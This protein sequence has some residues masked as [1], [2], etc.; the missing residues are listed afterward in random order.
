MKI[1]YEYSH[2]GGS[3]ILHVRYPSYE[4]EIYD[5]IARVK[6]HR[7]KVSKEKTKKGRALY[8]PISMNEQFHAAF[9]E[10]GFVE[11]RD[12]YTITVP[13]S[14]ISIAGA[15]KQVDF[16]KE[17]VLVEVQFGKYAFMF[18]DMAKFQYFFNENKADVGIEIVPCHGLH[19]EMSSGVSYGEQLVYDIERLKR[20][21]PAVPV[22]VILIDAD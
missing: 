15:Y 17:K 1:V 12:T 14:A 20:H 21:F 22:K 4:R 19:K 13:N 9:Q 2:L 3:E 5:V 11:L 7:T 18:Y 10:R 6:G 16:V 8:S